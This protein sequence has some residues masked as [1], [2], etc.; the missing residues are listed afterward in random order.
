M[1]RRPYAFLVYESLP[2]RNGLVMLGTVPSKTKLYASVQAKRQ[3]PGQI[4][5]CTRRGLGKDAD[6]RYTYEVFGPA[7]SRLH[8]GQVMAADADDARELAALRW[9]D[10][11]LELESRASAS[12]GSLGGPII[13]EA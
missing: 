9:P 10:R 7:A 6:G 13:R 8:L 3:W 12:V 4:L 1:R 2:E 11:E 5:D